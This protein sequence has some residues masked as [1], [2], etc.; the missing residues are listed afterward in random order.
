MSQFTE[1]TFTVPHT[2]K[3][4]TETQLTYSVW[5]KDVMPWI[6][7]MVADPALSEHWEWHAN[8]QYL[9]TPGKEPE[10]FITTPMSADYAWEMEVC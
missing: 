10:R 5:V 1:K 2:L 3:D 9:H 7:E 6:E 8:R 4:G